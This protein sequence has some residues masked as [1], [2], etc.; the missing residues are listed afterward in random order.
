[1]QLGSG[2]GL[3]SLAWWRY[4]LPLI[5]SSSWTCSVCRCR[6]SVCLLSVVWHQARAPSSFLL[7]RNSRH[8]RLL[9][10]ASSCSQP[11]TDAQQ[12]P[13]II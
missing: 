6:W 11:A 7:P 8:S 10:P 5:V 12:Q 13:Y 2:R 4:S 1:M 9:H 3:L